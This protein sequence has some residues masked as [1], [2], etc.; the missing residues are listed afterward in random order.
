MA[1]VSACSCTPFL[2]VTYS[3]HRLE[4]GWGLVLE[5]GWVVN[6]PWLP[7]TLIGW[8]VDHWGAPLALVGW[9][10]LHWWLPWATAGSLLT[11]GVRD[12]R[13]D[14]V[15]ILLIIPVLWLLCL[16]VRNH[17]R[18]VVK[19]VG[20]LGSILVDHLVWRI[21]IPVLW[22]GGLWVLNLGLL[23]PVGRLL[24]FWVIDLLWW[25]DRWGEV[26]KEA[27]VTERLAVDLDLEG[28]IWLDDESVERAALADASRWW[29]LQVLLLVLASDWVLVTEDEVDLHVQLAWEESTVFATKRTLLVEPHLSGPN[30]IM[31]GEALENSSA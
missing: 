26:L 14:P 2:D 1:E 6:L 19:P 27:A 23:N 20:W 12:H 10:L 11:L 7:N 21:L 25:L 31:Y 13:W 29:V 30:M 15:T 5:I 4:V 28:L 9:V 8:V 17:G 3:A 22:L 16:W 24:V 18:L